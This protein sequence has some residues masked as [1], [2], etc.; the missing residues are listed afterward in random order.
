MPNS[1]TPEPDTPAAAAHTVTVPALVTLS[2]AARLL[3]LSERTVR[4]LIADGTLRA[5]RIGHRTL[6]IEAASIAEAGVPVTAYTGGGE[7]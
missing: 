6:R 5:R 4:R 2:T 3:D 1:A 7:R